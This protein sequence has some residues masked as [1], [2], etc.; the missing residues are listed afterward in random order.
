VG[1]LELL[2]VVRALR[3]FR[4]YLEGSEFTVCTDHHNLTH[5]QTQVPPSKRYARWIEYLQQFSGTIVYVK[6]SKNL[7]DALPRRPDHV[8]VHTAVMS[9]NL[10]AEIRAAYAKDERFREERFVNKLTFDERSSLYLYQDREIVVPGDVALK[11]KIL[12]ECHDVSVSGHFGVD[13]TLYAVC[14]RF[15]WPRMRWYVAQY[16]LSCPVCQR[17]KADKHKPA[18]LLQPV[19]VPDYPWDSIE[20]GLCH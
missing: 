11:Q 17:I 13:K 19:S 3:E 18:G 6:G 14:S 10:L 20:Y 9:V 8:H 2:A 7:A 1:E 5:L 16:V 15:W 4:P 12:H